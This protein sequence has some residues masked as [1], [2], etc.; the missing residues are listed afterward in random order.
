M[1]WSVIALQFKSSN[2]S[3]DNFG[4]SSFDGDGDGGSKLVVTLLLFF[5]LFDN[6]DSFGNAE[7]DDD[8]NDNNSKTGGKSFC[9]S[10]QNS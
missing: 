5:R 2:D 8:A 4:V 3:N 1:Y 10:A 7:A 6:I 9:L